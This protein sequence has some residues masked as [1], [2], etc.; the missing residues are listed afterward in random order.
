MV[1]YFK[2]YGKKINGKIGMGNKKSSERKQ[3]SIRKFKQ[4]QKENKEKKTSM[5]ISEIAQSSKDN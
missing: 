2:N 1:L 4:T 3:Q 5:N